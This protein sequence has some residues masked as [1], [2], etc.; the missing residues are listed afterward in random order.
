LGTKPF[1]LVLETVRLI[2]QVAAPAVA[3]SQALKPERT[4]NPE[5]GS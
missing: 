5:N 3:V 2:A 4:R 1:D